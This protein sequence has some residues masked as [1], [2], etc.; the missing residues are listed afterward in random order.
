MRAGVRAAARGRW[1]DRESGEP[2]QVC[3]VGLP[4]WWEGLAK[5]ADLLAA[6]LQECLGA[7][8]PEPAE[9]IP[10]VLALPEPSKR[11]RFGSLDERLFAEVERRLGTQMH[12][13]SAAVL[14]GNAAGAAALIVANDL[15][16]KGRARFCIVAG[17][18]GY[19]EQTIIDRLAAERRLLTPANSN[20]FIPGEAACAVLLAKRGDPAGR[21][22]EVLSVATANEPAPVGSGEP[23]RAEGMSRAVGRALELAGSAFGSIGYRLS[24]LNGEHYKFKEATFVAGRHDSGKR[25]EPLE[26]WHPIEFIGEIGAGIVPCML[27]YALHATL[28]EYEPGALA[29]C[30][31]GSDGGLRSAAVLRHPTTGG[32]R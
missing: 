16:A 4:Q 24:D 14:G 31:A 25:T 21:R 22:V 7:A 2:I 5:Y 19:L 10:C 1:L 6:S 27:G 18:D 28:G 8:R 26:E 13:E 23:F 32:R 29:L 30:H 15:L 12:P 20:G 17:V 11:F 9:S 3:R